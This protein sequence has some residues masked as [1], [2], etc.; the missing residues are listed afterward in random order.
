[1]FYFR[2]ERKKK[3]L[4]FEAIHVTAKLKINTS[5]LSFQEGLLVSL[6]FF[7][8]SMFGKIEVGLADNRQR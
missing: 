8:D 7:Y 6:P 4:K 5:C 1:M 2:R 3:S